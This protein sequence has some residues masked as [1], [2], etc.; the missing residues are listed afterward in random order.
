MEVR[1]GTNPNLAD[2][3]ADGVPDATDAFAL[4]PGE[5]VDTD[6]DGIGNNADTD[7]DNDGRGDTADNC[8]LVANPDQ[9]DDDRDGIGN[10]CDPTPAPCWECLPNRGGWRAIMP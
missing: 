4:E 6:S 9:A 5:S 3:D 10:A 1:L 8:Q 2:T 7:D